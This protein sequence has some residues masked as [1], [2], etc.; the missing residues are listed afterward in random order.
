MQS[1]LIKM[2]SG[3]RTE[4][5][6]IGIMPAWAGP[7]HNF[8]SFV[9][10]RIKHARHQFAFHC[11][12]KKAE[13]FFAFTRQPDIASASTGKATSWADLYL[14]ME[15]QF[16]TDTAG[17][18]NIAEMSQAL[19]WWLGLPKPQVAA[20][21][22]PRDMSS[23]CRPAYPNLRTETP[24]TGVRGRPYTFHI[25][26]N[27]LAHPFAF[28]LFNLLPRLRDLHLS[29]AALLM[30]SVVCRLTDKP[31]STKCCPT[32][33]ILPKIA[34]ES[35]RHESRWKSSSRS[36]HGD[37]ISVEVMSI[38]LTRGGILLMVSSSIGIGRP[39]R[40]S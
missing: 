8:Q 14:A 15:A 17:S 33:K 2:S 32:P 24:R 37:G 22:T 27:G 16:E 6:D 40:G 5:R 23:G 30:G 25:Q 21:Q 3:Y 4:D 1:F 7:T 12:C 26:R 29:H 35:T 19:G 36:R 9:V 28:N 38:G 34:Q 20:E 18:E 31:L 39:W 10:P 11:S 13:R